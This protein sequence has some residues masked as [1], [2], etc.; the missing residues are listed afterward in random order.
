[1]RCD[2]LLLSERRLW[3]VQVKVL[4]PESYWFNE[5]GKVVSVDQSGIRYP[6]VVR[7]PTVNYAGVSTN[8]YS[9]EEVQEV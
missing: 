8:N 7:F 6:V 9:L 3:C 5:V 4:R 2:T 1:M